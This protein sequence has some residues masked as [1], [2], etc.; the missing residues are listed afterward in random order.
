MKLGTAT[1]TTSPTTKDIIVPYA[2][3]LF[4][5]FNDQS[6]NISVDSFNISIMLNFI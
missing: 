6:D 5:V 2:L 4:V 3:E 1:T